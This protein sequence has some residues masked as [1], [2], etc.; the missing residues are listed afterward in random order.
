MTAFLSALIKLWG[1][2]FSSQFYAVY[3]LP[4]FA[5]FIVIFCVKVVW[6]VVRLN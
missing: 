2:F 6:A 1:I 4:V 5:M 3:L